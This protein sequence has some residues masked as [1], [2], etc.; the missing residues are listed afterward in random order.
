MVTAAGPM[1]NWAGNVTFSAAG[2]L[3]PGSVAELQEMVARERQLRPLGTGHSFSPVADTTGYLVSLAGLPPLLEVANDRRTV[4]VSAGLRYSDIAPRLN[5]AGLALPNLASLPHISVA[6]AVATGTH[7]SGDKNG[8][9]GS[10]VAGLSMVTASGDLMSVSR[11][12]DPA[13]LAAL[14]VSLGACGIVTAL[15]LDTVPSFNVR[16]YVYRDL[17]FSQ[18]AAHFDEVTGAGYSVSMFTDWAADRFTSVWVK[19]AGEQEPPPPDWL[20][21]RLSGVG[22]HMIPDMPAANCTAQL[23]LPG[24]WHERLP[25]FRADFTPSAGS[26]LQSEYLVPRRHAVPALAALAAIRTELAPVI[27]AGELRTVAADQLWLSPAYQRDSAAFHFTWVPDARAVLPVVASVE[28]ALAPFA[29]RPH[30]GKVFV[31]PPGRVARLYPRMDDFR[32]VTRELDPAGKFSNA[33]LE[34]IPLQAEGSIY[35]D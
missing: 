24:P 28:A 11:D 17:A 26:E 13:R 33:M 1:R 20:G 4:T 10:A 19:L 3:R 6:G 2:L 30:W 29:A 8:S 14:V 7:G 15:T 22:V 25:H 16:Q 31:L 32:K 23:G 18:A 27:L 12:A 5:A 21:S 35:P 9:L 34:R